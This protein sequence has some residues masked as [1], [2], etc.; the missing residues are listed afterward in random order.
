MKYTI[1][2]DDNF[3]NGAEEERYL[4]G[5]YESY[6]EAVAVCKKIVDDFMSKG[7]RNGMSFKELWEGYMMFGEDPFIESKD[8]ECTFSAWSY[9]KQR[10]VELCLA[11]T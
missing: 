6:Q 8:P 1:F 11:I 5:E 10:C 7:Y 4:L 3:H 2:V 9:A